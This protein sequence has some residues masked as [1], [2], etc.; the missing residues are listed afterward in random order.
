MF[1]PGEHM[2]VLVDMFLLFYFNLKTKNLQNLVNAIKINYPLK[3][4]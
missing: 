2:L 1:F 4:V 3:C